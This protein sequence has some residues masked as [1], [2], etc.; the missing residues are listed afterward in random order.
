MTVGELRVSTESLADAAD[1]F[2]S[3]FL[4][5]DWQAPRNRRPASEVWRG[6]LGNQQEP[7]S[8]PQTEA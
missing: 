7:A 4:G 3:V 6:G 2:K 8:A 5:K 1:L